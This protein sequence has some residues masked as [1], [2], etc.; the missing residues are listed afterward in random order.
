VATSNPREAGEAALE[1]V[2]A[3][4]AG[5]YYS[6]VVC[7]LK[8]LATDVFHPGEGWLGPEHALVQTIQRTYDQHP[9]AQQFFSR[10]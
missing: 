2:K 10:G 9:F 5:N 6:A 4:V 7:D 1:A 3:V 8:T